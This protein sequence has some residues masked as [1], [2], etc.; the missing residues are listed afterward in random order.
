MNMSDTNEPES[1]KTYLLA[2][3]SN[4]DSI[5]VNLNTFQPFHYISRYC[6][7]KKWTFVFQKEN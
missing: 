5:T 6:K 3:A 2:G 4:K 1:G 7:N